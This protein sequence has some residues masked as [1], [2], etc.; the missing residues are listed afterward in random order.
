MTATLNSASC[1]GGAARGERDPSAPTI[2]LVGPPN[3][4][5]T[6]LFNAISGARAAVGNWPGTTIDVGR[7]RWRIATET[8]E[9][10]DLPGAYSLD[11]ISPD[12]QLTRSLLIGA[13]ADELP[14]AVVVVV[15]ATRLSAGLYLFAQLRE[16]GLPLV[17]ALTMSDVVRRRG[18]VIDVD[19]LR[20][21]LGVEVV[22]VNPR[23]GVGL[24]ALTAATSRVVVDGSTT[25]PSL[26][27]PDAPD[28]ADAADAADR[29]FEW[30]AEV[31]AAAVSRT[32]RPRPTRSDLVDRWVMS[33]VVGPLVFIAAMWSVF[34]ATTALAA[35]LQR[36][37]GSFFAGPVANGALA[38]LTSLGLGG[39]WLER[40][41][42][43]G[44]IGGVGLLMTF[45]PL[46]ALMFALLAVLEDSGYLARAA[47][48]A[49]RAMR[50]IG[51]PG[52]AFI[53]LIIGFGCNVPAISATRVLADARH[54]AMTALLVPFTSCSARLTVY[55][56]VASMFFPGNVGNAVFVMYL[57]S[58]ALVIVIGLALR[59]TLWRAMG[60][61][62]MMLD[63]PPYQ[64]PHLRLMTNATWVRLR[65]FLRTAGGVIVLAVA[66][67]WFMQALPVR[68]SHAFG[69]VPVKD[70]AY[71]AVAGE[72]APVFAPAGFGD[73]HATGALAVGFV[74]KEAVVSSW[75]QTYATQ[76]SAD[77][78][79]PG[80]LTNLVRADFQRS[81]G[82]H[83]SPAA[84]AFLM[85][86]LA[87]TP[88]AA[89]LAAQR[90]EIGW[91][92]AAFG[93]AVQLATAWTLAVAV[94]QIGRWFA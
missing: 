49:D 61:T 7:G 43:D 27:T 45:A 5:K 14:A 35:P 39:G 83:Q 9:L 64:A 13:V 1:H 59:R 74:A 82:G 4:G 85:F 77:A 76:G 71:A 58:V 90:R 10:I 81:S 41:V 47:V 36:L 70:S 21:L 52:Q 63:L 17:L 6:T 80:Y 79:P 50:A 16:R 51:L 44:L 62:P 40:F 57:A 84:W 46:M 25:A 20:D 23:T 66:A 73:W 37:M 15:A 33:P 30:V 56:L 8:A 18:A 69:D 26:A 78:H 53:P 29:R 91:R 19:K 3:V 54:R 32:A 12:E 68:G 87:Y 22:T 93:L 60:E 34:Q 94:F 31:V 72:V 65:A 88:C 42:V 11:A 2:A 92:L 38:L 89:T 24:D 67:V 28:A 75:A 48:V 55:V 86:V